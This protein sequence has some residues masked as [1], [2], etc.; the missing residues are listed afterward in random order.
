MT[1]HA[2]IRTI[3]HFGERMGEINIACYILYL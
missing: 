2:K 1:D 3:A